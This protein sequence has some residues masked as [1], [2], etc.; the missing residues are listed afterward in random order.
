MSYSQVERSGL[1][2]ESGF[3][4]NRKAYRT[5]PGGIISS[6]STSGYF[7]HQRAR[8]FWF[9]VVNQ[10]NRSD[11]VIHN[12]SR[13][14]DGRRAN[15]AKIIGWSFANNP[16]K[17][18]GCRITSCRSYRFT[19]CQISARSRITVNNIITV[20]WFARAPA[21][22]CFQRKRNK[23]HGNYHQDKFENYPFFFHLDESP[24]KTL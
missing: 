3:L 20:I 21:A 18:A 4:R 17:I 19:C 23:Q 7:I 14:L 2:Y 11:A 10:N 9:I 6:V 5:M 12:L 1:V 16:G 22:G 8:Y 15:V 13:N 24:K